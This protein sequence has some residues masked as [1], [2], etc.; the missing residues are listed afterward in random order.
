ME[1]SAWEVEDQE[2]AP[3]GEI[4]PGDQGILSWCTVTYSGF[5]TAWI[6]LLLCELKEKGLVCMRFFFS[7]LGN[8]KDTG[9]SV[10]F[11]CGKWGVMRMAN[12]TAS[13]RDF[14]QDFL[15]VTITRQLKMAGEDKPAGV[16]LTPAKPVEVVFLWPGANVGCCLTRS[17]IE[18]HFRYRWFNGCGSCNKFKFDT[19]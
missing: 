2:E 11:K 8:R 12:K 3:L 9:T 10:Y 13:P 7:P 19:I 17:D 16:Q 1:K 18:L 14:L 4:W 6:E 15:S 5:N